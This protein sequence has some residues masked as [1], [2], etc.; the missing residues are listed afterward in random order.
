MGFCI[1]C[2]KNVY[3]TK[4]PH[5]FKPVSTDL[6]SRAMTMFQ[7]QKMLSH[8]SRDK[9]QDTYSKKAI[10]HPSSALP[11][12]SRPQRA[13]PQFN[14]SESTATKRDGYQL[15]N[16]ASC[17]TR[18]S[19]W[20][21]SNF[22]IYKST[23]YC[24]PC[25]IQ[26]LQCPLCKTSV[27]VTEPQISFHNHIYH[28]TCF[29][30]TTCSTPLTESIAVEGSEMSIHCTACQPEQPRSPPIPTSSRSTNFME[31]QRRRTS[32]LLSPKQTIFK[33]EDKT[34]STLTTRRTRERTLSTPTA[35]RPLSTLIT[36]RP[37]STFTEPSSPVSP[38]IEPSS[39][40]SP[41]I[42]PSSPL[43]PIIEAPPRPVSPLIE[44][45]RP[46]TP[47]H[48]KP[49]TVSPL[50]ETPRSESPLVESP[51]STLPQKPATKLKKK[52]IKK[53]CE[54]C[55][56]LISR[57]DYR[58]L[59]TPNGKT[60]CYHAS[61]LTC[62]KCEH[63]FSDLDFCTDGKF[64]YHIKC[65]DKDDLKHDSMSEEELLPRTPSPVHHPLPLPPSD[66]N[67]K[68]LDMTLSC[69]KCNQAVTD[70]Y[71]ELANHFYHKECLLCAG[72]NQTVPIDKKLHRMNDKLYCHC[73]TSSVELNQ[74][75][76]ETIRIKTT[77]ITS[78]SDIFKSRKRVLPRLGG[79]RTCAGCN[80]SMPFSDTQPGP[81]A[82][83]W[84]K[85]CLRCVGCHKQMD[86]D[87][88]MTMNEETG[89]SMVHCRECLDD[90]PKSKF[91]R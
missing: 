31:Y 76:R 30:C 32:A 74:E 39:I 80:Q 40:I 52:I 38:L 67:D 49:R 22:T 78:P 81:N 51:L 17:N 82:S 64:F 42:D 77:V 90:I 53:T 69:N 61:C 83:R 56:T 26:K 68:P 70:T 60:M 19:S 5:C 45:P 48:E 18:Q 23:Y 7:D 62:A 79:V 72:C 6:S 13:M 29:Q 12:L 3:S 44:L 54:E 37:L 24:K 71:L 25:L 11:S 4:C 73:C 35:P 20:S 14:M 63:H 16:C 36:P 89:I 34:P 8:R 21:D 84:H 1:H 75:E 86:S 50:I 58:G 43:S 28:A 88:H 15:K 33:P 27:K 91:V 55:G 10:F 87:A 9:W 65:P 85:K 47:P 66:Y 2:N 41:L 57:K 59:K 46:V